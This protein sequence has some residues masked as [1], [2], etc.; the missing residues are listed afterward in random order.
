MSSE[1]TTTIIPPR[2]G[3]IGLFGQHSTTQLDS[4]YPEQ[5]AGDKTKANQ[6]PGGSKLA[7]HAG[8]NS[9]SRSCGDLAWRS[10]N[11]DNTAQSCLPECGNTNNTR[12]PD[13]LV[14]VREQSAESRGSRGDPAEL[15]MPSEPLVGP[16][17]SRSEEEEAARVSLAR[18]GEQKP[19]I[20]TSSCTLLLQTPKNPV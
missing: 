6:R 13:D 9:D 1:A 19:K 3:R 15:R 7:G 17:E 10:T 11:G 8:L 5:P 2:G 18:H 20:F 14:T 16:A 12:Q 4:S